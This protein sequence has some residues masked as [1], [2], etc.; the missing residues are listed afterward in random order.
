MSRDPI[1]PEI[2]NGGA[3]SKQADIFSFAML[4]IEVRHRLSTGCARCRGPSQPDID[5]GILGPLLLLVSRG[6]WSVQ[7]WCKVGGHHNPG[8]QP[9]Q[10]GCGD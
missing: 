2:V 7:G 6:L 10:D 9:L 8:T 3:Y 5:T 1:A 4:I